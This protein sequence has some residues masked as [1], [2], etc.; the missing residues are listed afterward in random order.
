MKFKTLFAGLLAVLLFAMPALAQTTTNQTT[1]SAAVARED[2]TV[3]VTAAGTIAAGHIL[4]ADREAMRVAS[5]SGT[6]VT[7]RR[8]Q[9]GTT[10]VAHASGA[11]VFSGPAS[12]GPFLA[13]TSNKQGSCTSSAE[14]YLPQIHIATG[15]LY[16]CSSSEWN[17][18]LSPGGGHFDIRTNQNNRVVRINSRNYD[19]TSG[20]VVGFQSK[21]RLTADGTQTVYGFQVSANMSDGVDLTSSGSVVGGHVDT[22]MRGTTASTIAGDVRGLQI[23]LVTDDAGAK[24]YS[25]Y[26]AGIRIRAAFSATAI[27]GNFVPLRIEKP[28]AQ[29]GSQTYDAV[30][31]LTSTI[32]GVWDDTDA[33]SGD[34]EAGYIKV[35]VNGNARYILLFSDAP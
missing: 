31:D 19:A 15:D 5:I 22:Y 21:P 33:D 32:A 25:G 11:V 12:A 3:P 30:L 7:V 29:T 20:D 13:S 1:F 26:V 34:T 10:A 14:G 16:A 35:I 4:Y 2:T 17:R 28:E 23:E 6:T 8:G 24:T 9:E 27:T 18:Q